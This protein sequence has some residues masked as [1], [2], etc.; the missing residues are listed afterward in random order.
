MQAA[1]DHGRSDAERALLQALLK[2]GAAPLSDLRA[3]TL[4]APRSSDAAPLQ[5]TQEL[6]E[7]Y[8][9]DVNDDALLSGALADALPATTPDLSINAEAAAIAI[10]GAA[11]ATYFRFDVASWQG[12]RGEGGG[13]LATDEAAQAYVS[14]APSATEEPPRYLR[15]L[16]AEAQTRALLPIQLQDVTAALVGHLCAT[17]A[18]CRARPRVPHFIP[19]CSTCLLHH[20]RPHASCARP[21]LHVRFK[22]RKNG[23]VCAQAAAPHL[24]AQLC[25]LEQLRDL[26]EHNHMLAAEVLLKMAASDS[27]QFPA[28]LESLTRMPDPSVH[29]MEVVK[30]LTAATPLPEGFLGR[31]IN[32]CIAACEAT[33]RKGAQNRPVRLVC[34]FLHS[35]VRAKI[36]N[37]AEVQFELRAF[38]LRFL[39]IKEALSLYRLLQHV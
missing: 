8:A 20:E 10:A 9:T 29:S 32:A 3:A 31:Y 19:L 30:R 18:C 12:A 14:G 6:R 37:V 39:R 36:V 16:V 25:A 26:V 28:Y 27:P 23:C 13:T 34:V 5:S 35:L 7:Q 21:L 11:P 17:H 15:D 24:A 4:A 33:E 1:G 22:M 2:G 38:C